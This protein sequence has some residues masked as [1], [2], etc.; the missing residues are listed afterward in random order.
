MLNK[1]DA[2]IFVQSFPFLTCMKSRAS[3]EIIQTRL[4]TNARGCDFGGLD[5]SE[6]SKD[7]D[8]LGDSNGVPIA[9]W[10]NSHTP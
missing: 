8:V 2:Q 1:E 3:T 10:L 7:T 4:L 6:K 5:W 9:S